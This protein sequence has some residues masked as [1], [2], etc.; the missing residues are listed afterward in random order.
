L[1]IIGGF[2]GRQVSRFA[3]VAVIVGCLLFLSDLRAHAQSSFNAE[4]ARVE[5]ARFLADLIRIDTQDPPG[6][7]S[8]VAHYLEG[9]LKEAGIESELLEVVPG[10]ASIVARLRGDGSKRPLLLMA[11][12]DVVPVDRAHWTVDPFAA[13]ERDG[14]LYGRGASDDKAMLAAN[15]EVFLQL[16]RLQVPLARDVIF[17]A[18]ASEEMSSSAGMKAVVEKYWVKI[19]CEFALNEGGTSR[20]ADGKIEYMGVA[21]SEKLPRGAKLQATG[22]S[23]HGSVPRL[24]NAVVHLAAAVAKA[25]TWE[26]PS[27]L[28]ETTR[29]FFQR[30]ASISP[31]EEAAWYRDVLNPQVQEQLKVKK[32]QYYSMLRTSVVPTM[33]SAGIKSNVVPPTAEATLDIRALPDEDLVKFRE[34]LAGVIND[35]QV[36][37][38]AE[39]T[40]FSMVAAPASRLHTEMFDALERAQK[41]VAPNSITLPTMTTGATDSSF[42]RAKG[43]QAY[44]IGVPKTDEENR[45]VHGNDERIEIKE[46]GVFVQY[47]FAAVTTVAAKH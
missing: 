45:T 15:L 23:G 43:V 27:R 2:G 9:V 28:N 46:L 47:E 29:E 10:R 6:N 13:T 32:P 21:T 31:P 26:T 8:R 7:E 5:A 20:V 36:T 30:L 25:G 33:L 17:L 34:M 19:D 12:E 14:A 44:G 37:V 1:F 35:P 22:S 18:E 4:Q 40:E 38:V 16:K 41:E 42:L 3:K 11:H 24:D 39:D